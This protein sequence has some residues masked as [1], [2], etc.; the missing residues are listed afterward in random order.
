MNFRL[1]RRFRFGAVLLSTAALG[2]TL[3]APTADAGD[4][5]PLRIISLGADSASGGYPTLSW[6]SYGIFVRAKDPTPDD[7]HTYTV[8]ATPRDG[9]DPVTS[10]VS[11]YD[12][13]GSSIFTSVG[14]DLDLPMTYDV[15]ITE[16]DAEG[17][18]VEESAPMSFYY[19]AVKH[20][21]SV[22]LS[23]TTK[24]SV[25]AGSL[26]RLRW[27]GRYEKGATI[28]TTVVLEDAKTG[29]DHLTPR[30]FLACR[31]AYCATR[32]GEGRYVKSDD[33]SLISRFRVPAGRAGDTLHIAVFGVM[34]TN[35]GAQTAYWGYSYTFKVTR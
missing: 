25:R 17:A 30:D 10:A 9:G 3:L 7:S 23:T 26:V 15:V 24:H 6:G 34:V 22:K 35:R 14:P 27:K 4:V 33:E 2:V 32:S 31:N 20:P 21:R 29:F 8:T 11:E 5:M 28:S 18:V 19:R 1:L 12:I 16:S 13:S